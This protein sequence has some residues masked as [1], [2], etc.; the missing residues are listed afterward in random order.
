MGTRGVVDDFISGSGYALKGIRV[1]YRT[2]VLWKYALMPML[3]VIAINGICSFLLFRVFLPVWQAALR[4]YFL[5]RGWETLAEYIGTGLW[6]VTLL[7]YIFIVNVCLGIMYEVV[8]ALFFERMVRYYE[9][10]KYG[11]ARNPGLG[12]RREFV[13]II[14]SIVYSSCTLLLYVPFFLISFFLPFLSL[15]L[16]AFF[17]GYRYA[18][19]YCGESGFNRGWSLRGLQANFAG[20]RGL[21]YGF[22]VVS[23]ILLLL[24][25][26]S[27]FFI[28]GFVIGGTMMVNE[29]RQ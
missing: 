25:F 4:D 3:C 6:W 21:L 22:G 10:W 9:Y 12:F 26:F 20:H 27:L 18:V 29:E 19:S 17:I 23:F 2:S 15:V 13:N 24:P 11:H 7:F 8:G 28:P 5:S 16:Q 14:D 1:F